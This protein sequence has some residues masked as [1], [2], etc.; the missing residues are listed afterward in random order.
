MY[1]VPRAQIDGG[2]K[3]T[4]TKNINLLKNILW[5]NC[6]FHPHVQ[7]KGARS[8]NIIVPQAEGY[9]QV[10]TIQ[11][12]KG[13]D[14]HCYYFPEIT[15]TLLSHNDILCSGKFINQHSGEFILD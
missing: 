6:W 2:L 11:E 7:I 13:I 12:G 10:Q 15:S 9:L 5:Y 14:V 3:C 1:D 8:N 4:V